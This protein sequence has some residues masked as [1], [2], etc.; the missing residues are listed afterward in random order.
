[1]ERTERRRKVYQL[2]DGERDYQDSLPN[3]NETHDMSH[4]VADW[5][6]FMEERILRAKLA[7]Y[8]EDELAAMKEVRVVSALGVVA[9]EHNT[10]PA[11]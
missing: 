6:I 11:R 5:V 3:H 2:L 4:S 7:L 9:M 8:N 1:M 10:T